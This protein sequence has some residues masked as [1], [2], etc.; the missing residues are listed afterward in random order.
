MNEITGKELAHRIRC[1]AIRMTHN[2]RASHI[3]SIMSIADI[4]GMLYGE[5]MAIYPSDPKND[6][7]DRL[8]LSKG[9]AGVA[10]YAALAETGFFPIEELDNYYSNGCYLSGHIS[11]KNVTGVEFST[12]SLG[13]GVCVACG[14]ALAAK[15]DGKKHHVFSIIG[16]GEC[17]EGS[18]WEMAM[19]A[20]QFKLDNFTVI[21]D[22]N[23][24]QAMD[25]C[26][27]TIDPIDLV[28]KWDAFGWNTLSIDG[29]N[30]S[31]IKSGIMSRIK[32]KPTCIIAHTIKGKG[33]SFMENNI[34]WHYK[35]PQGEYYENALMELEG[36]D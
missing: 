20:N 21:V 35:D 8:I 26:K 36:K 4:V 16:D 22:H 13:H 28:K 11:H 10:V 31:E 30:Y 7:R 3:G 12:G 14:M 34:I 2:A 6:K 5:I 17:N 1:H 9:H 32:D 27:N 19:F 24:F 23:K 33:V 25:T 29:H 15:L 18:V